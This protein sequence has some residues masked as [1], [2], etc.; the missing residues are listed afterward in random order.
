MQ[1]RSDDA[2]IETLEQRCREIETSIATSAE[3][4]QC[5]LEE[6]EASRRP[7]NEHAKSLVA[8]RQKLR[9]AGIR[10]PADRKY[11]TS[12]SKLLQEE[13]RRSMR[14]QS[15]QRIKTILQDFCGLKQVAGINAEGRNSV[16]TSVLVSE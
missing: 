15:R 9:K 7:L 3:H 14:Q 11:L 2:L 8:E 13:I 12:I 1:Q 4:W 6:Q 10:D 16:N 5:D